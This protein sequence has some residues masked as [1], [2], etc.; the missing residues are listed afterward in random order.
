MASTRKVLGDLNACANQSPAQAKANVISREAPVYF[1]S[2]K[3]EKPKAK[4]AAASGTSSSKKRKA[5]TSLEDD[6][7]AYKQ[8][9]DDIVK[10]SSFEDDRMPSAQ[11]V[12]NKIHKLL[13]AGI[14][15][16]AEFA[17]ALGHRNANTLSTFLRQTGPSGGSGSS[18]YYNAWVWFRQREVAKIKMPDMN[19]KQKQEAETSAGAGGSTSKTSKSTSPPSISDLISGI[20]LP[21]EETDEVP[22]WDTCDEIR[23]KINAHLK[24]PGVTQA[25]FC[26]DLYAQLHAPKVKSIQSKQLSD[27][28]HGKG[29]RTGVKSTVFYAAYVFFEKL[30]IATGKPESKH[31]LEMEDIWAWNGGFDRTIDNRT[32]FIGS[33]GST[34]HFDRYGRSVST[35]G[36]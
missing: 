31:R 29:S 25:Q 33:V 1:V 23:R 34:V 2:E 18:S 20:H 19:K 11:S 16:R 28:L 13:D 27:F 15:T 17:R 35:P 22:I 9:L 6:I 26:R 7:A 32:Q 4:S 14:M 5:E 24:T 3:A 8:N 36:Y 30:R 12:R 21:D 10:P